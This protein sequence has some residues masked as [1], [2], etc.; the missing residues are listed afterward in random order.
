MIIQRKIII[1]KNINSECD[2]LKET[3]IEH[4]I[5]SILYMGIFHIR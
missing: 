2:F 1:T 5:G 4:S 3:K